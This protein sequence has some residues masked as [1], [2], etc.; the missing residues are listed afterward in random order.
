M[1]KLLHR[2]SRKL[3]IYNPLTESHPVDVSLC[4]GRNG[5]LAEY[6]TVVRPPVCQEMDILIVHSPCFASRRG[7]E[8]IVHP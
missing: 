3:V 6:S 8:R 7:Q 4:F 5:E 1:G 2:Q